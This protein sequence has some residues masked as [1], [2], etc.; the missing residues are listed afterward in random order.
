MPGRTLPTIPRS[1]VES[2]NSAKSCYVTL[3]TRVFDITSFLEDH[4]GGGDLIIGYGGKDVTE[5][6]GDA[7]SHA[8]SEAAYEILED[9]LVGF[10]ATEQVMDAVTKSQHPANIVPLPPSEEGMEEL[11]ENGTADGTV[12]RPV[13]ATTGMSSAEDL[14][15]ETDTAAD[16]RTHKFLDLDRPLL[17]QVWNGGFSKAF[18]LEQVHRPRHYKGGE[19]APLFGNFLEPLSKT[20]WWIVP[21]IWLP[22]VMYGT[23]LASQGLPNVFHVAAYWILGL[24]LWTLVEYGLHRCLF[25]IDM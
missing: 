18:Y 17:M 22:A 2:R 12:P 14:S 1:D 9:N 8:H 4:P 11:R 24:C 13:H 7:I 5:I 23:W 15:K 3:G 6:M 10:V 20:P 25:H 19:S 21:T 16:Y